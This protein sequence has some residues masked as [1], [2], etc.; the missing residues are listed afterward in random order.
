MKRFL[1]LFPFLFLH[2]C[3]CPGLAQTY[4]E[5]QE[6][7][8]FNFLKN[9]GFEN[10]TA[11]WTKSGSCATAGLPISG[12]K[13]G[14]C[15][16]TGAAQTLFSQETAFTEYRPYIG[17]KFKASVYARGISTSLY[18][19]GLL[20]GVET[21]CTKVDEA[22][23]LNAAGYRE[24]AI[25]IDIPSTQSTSF[26]AGLRIKTT[27]SG[28]LSSNFENA[29]LGPWKGVVGL[30][31]PESVYSASISDASPSV[32]SNENT[33]WINGNCPVTSTST[34]TCTFNSGFFT[35]APNCTATAIAA[36]GDRLVQATAA[37]TPTTFTFTTFNT[38]GSQAIHS[39]YVQCQRSST[40]YANSQST[41]TNVVGLVPSKTRFSAKVSSAGVLS[42]IVNGKYF[43]NTTFAPTDT[44]LYTIGFTGLTSP[45]TCYT[46]VVTNTTSGNAVARKE[47]LETNSSV[48]VRTGNS[49]TASNF[50][51]TAYAFSVSCE[52]TGADEANARKTFDN[53]PFS[54][55]ESGVWTPVISS[56]T[57][58]TSTNVLGAN[59]MRMG[60]IVFGS[61]SLDVAASSNTTTSFRFTVPI[62]PPAGF[63]STAQLIGSG[64][65]WN[66]NMTGN[67]TAV[68][69]TSFGFYTFGAG[70]TASRTHNFNFSYRL[71]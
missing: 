15:T 33:D 48:A 42:N 65:A 58:L 36:T 41:V 32:V 37:A 43:S 19:C 28:A 3:G 23:S 35:S 5:K 55:M 52:L 64:G 16:G 14:S 31:R 20:D 11:Y 59:Y 25:P 38:A 6:T 62:T 57:N 4:L 9:P 49:T 40:D 8:V 39:F 24:Y 26:T 61:I 47:T 45:P 69:S 56:G 12:V 1:S 54:P 29:F 22:V 50:T 2:F 30:V 67:V 13:A 46:T 70:T 7:D 63:T 60:D 10:G 27:G 68:S 21:S 44:S 53:V 18:V 51:K 34:R 71:K 17:M 66:G